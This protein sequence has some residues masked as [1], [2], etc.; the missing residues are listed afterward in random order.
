[1]QY[2]LLILLLLVGCSEDDN[3]VADTTSNEVEI[4]WMLF[5]ENGYD[6]YTLLSSVP[7]DV[8]LINPTYVQSNTISFWDFID[9]ENPTLSFKYN[10]NEMFN[11]NLPCTCFN[12]ADVVYQRII[13]NIEMNYLIVFYNDD[14]HGL[15]YNIDMYEIIDYR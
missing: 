14:D 8:T 10:D 2:L 7:S 9:N 12:Q 5:K 11:F 13:Y 6:E 3:P 4:S 1:M 15:I